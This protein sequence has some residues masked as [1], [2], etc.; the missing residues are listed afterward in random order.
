[1]NTST[2]SP[3]VDSSVA[4]SSGSL[5]IANNP[6]TIGGDVVVA[7]SVVSA[8]G[9]PTIGGTVSTGATVA[10]PPALSLPIVR[11]ADAAPASWATSSWTSFARARGAANGAPAWALT[12]NM[13]SVAGA[14]WSVNGPLV[15][16]AV[17]TVLDARA[18]SDLV[19]NGSA[20]AVTLSLDSDLTIVAN[21]FTSNGTLNVVSADGAPHFLRIIVPWQGAD[22][23]DCAAS[24]SS[25]VSFQAGGVTMSPL[26]PTLLYSGG[27]VA[28]TNG[29]NFTG[30]VYGCSVDTSVNVTMNYSQV[31]L[32][33]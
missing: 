23:A 20:G 15:S 18:C 17:P 8:S 2:T 6:V 32:A 9:T 16:P 25:S 26:I 14:S 29:M 3:R 19:L 31:G 13:C 10:P 24:G 27:N 11:Y 30:Q 22:S 12:G 4:S 33:S 1:M 5:R 7:G 21:K 28:L